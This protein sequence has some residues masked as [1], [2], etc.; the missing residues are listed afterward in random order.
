MGHFNN[1]PLQPWLQMLMQKVQKIEVMDAVDAI[2]SPA[3]GNDDSAHEEIFTS[4]TNNSNLSLGS[5]L[6][7]WDS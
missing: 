2:P 3:L 4:H 5:A 7:P 1:L 6:S